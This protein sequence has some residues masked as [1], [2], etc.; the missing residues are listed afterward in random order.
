MHAIIRL[1]L[2][3]SFLGGFA[4]KAMA[5]DVTPPSV[6]TWAGTPAQER[7][8]LVWNTSTDD[9][10]VTAYYIYRDGAYIGGVPFD[11]PSG[12]EY[13]DSNTSPLTTY[14]YTVAARDA[15][16]NLSAQSTAVLFTTGIADTAVCKSKEK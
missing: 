15:A 4:L 12:L 3:A 1:L 10:S 5:Q 11:N 8:R 7:V 13:L 9:V 14:S 6:P 16:G 2:I